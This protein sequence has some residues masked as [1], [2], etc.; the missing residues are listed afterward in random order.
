M[1]SIR[2]QKKK[3]TAVQLKIAKIVLNNYV[4]STALTNSYN[5][6]PFYRMYSQCNMYHRLFMRKSLPFFWQFKPCDCAIHLMFFAAF[7]I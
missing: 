4:H 7:N 2:H 5:S 3:G 1:E 6:R